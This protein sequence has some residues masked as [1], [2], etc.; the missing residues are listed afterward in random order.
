MI[1]P[2]GCKIL[3]MERGPFMARAILVEITLDHRHMTTHVTLSRWKPGQS[4]DRAS[5]DGATADK[6][7]HERIYPGDRKSLDEGASAVAG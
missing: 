3:V 2:D 5:A 4:G 1:R 6:L 7:R